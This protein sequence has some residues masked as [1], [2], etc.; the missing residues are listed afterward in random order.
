MFLSCPAHFS[1]LGCR[2]VWSSQ[3]DGWSVIGTVIDLE[4]RNQN[5]NS[6]IISVQLWLTRKFQWYFPAGASWG[7]PLPLLISPLFMGKWKGVLRFKIFSSFT[8]S[9]KKKYLGNKGQIFI[10]SCFIEVNKS[11]IKIETWVWCAFYFNKL[12]HSYRE[13][14]IYVLRLG[15]CTF[16]QL[17][18]KFN[19]LRRSLSLVPC[20]VIVAYG[21]D[22]VMELIS[23]LGIFNIFTS[24]PHGFH[25]HTITIGIQKK[26]PA[27]L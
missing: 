19:I 20:K 21:Q 4:T 12:C 5:L 25:F 18:S 13:E 10:K 7:S 14:M 8:N 26:A 17:C 2:A 24:S 11:Y 9:S 3:E 1:W 23:C 6:N 16:S 27:C 15:W 22:I